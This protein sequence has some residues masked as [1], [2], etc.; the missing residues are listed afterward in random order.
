MAVDVDLRALLEQGYTLPAHWYSDP[1]IHALEREL[2]FSRYWQFAGPVEWLDQDGA[3]FSTRAG[4]IPVVVVRDGDEIRA[5]VNVCRHRAHIVAKDRGCKKTLQCP[6]HA[7]TY[8]L[9]GTLRNAP[10]AQMEGDFHP[11]ELGLLPVAVDTWGPLVFVNPDVDAAP[12]LDALGPLPGHIAA[13]GIDLTALRLRRVEPTISEFNWKTAIE[14][15]LECYHCQVAH[16]GFSRVI[17]VGKS[18]YELTTDGLLLSQF[19][20]AKTGDDPRRPPMP[21]G[22]VTQAQY[23]I[24]FPSSSVDLVPGP[25]NLQAYAWAPLSTTRMAST[26]FSWFSEETTEEEIDQIVAFNNEVSA[27]DEALVDSVQEGL[28]SGAVPHGKLMPESEA[29]IGRFQRLLYDALTGA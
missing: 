28:D 22:I 8:G 5:F 29:L 26:T 4:H 24:L 17:D 9:D 27:E 19:G 11:E 25:P 10:R 16:P 6:Y 1:D 15:T 13:S 20:P 3:Y 18:A 23:H 7:W 12:L 14:N 2:V 21:A